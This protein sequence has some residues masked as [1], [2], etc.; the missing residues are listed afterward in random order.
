MSLIAVMVNCALIGMSGLADRMFPDM[1]T[2]ERIVFIV[3]LEVSQLIM[4]QW[5]HK[6][7]ES[8]VDVGSCNGL[9]L[10]GNKPLLEEILSSQ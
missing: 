1:G 6:A 7:T 9:V 4:A 10:S 5:R 8:L 3:L 2:A